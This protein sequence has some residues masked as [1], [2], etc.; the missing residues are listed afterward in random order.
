MGHLDF[1]TCTK[2][3]MKDADEVEDAH[4]LHSATEPENFQLQIPS[5]AKQAHGFSCVHVI[6]TGNP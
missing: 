1:Q 3:S 4:N 5:L 2:V 6:D